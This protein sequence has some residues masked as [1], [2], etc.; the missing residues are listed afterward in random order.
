MIDGVKNKLGTYNQWI[1]LI[2][3]TYKL[4]FVPFSQLLAYYGHDD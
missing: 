4:V 3:E 1:G 2:R